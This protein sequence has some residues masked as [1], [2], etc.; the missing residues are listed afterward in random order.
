MF[1]FNEKSKYLIE[2]VLPVGC[3]ARATHILME[4]L[5]VRLERPRAIRWAF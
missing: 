5:L 4:D 3:V 2:R 1:K